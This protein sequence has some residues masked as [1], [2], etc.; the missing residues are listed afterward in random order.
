MGGRYQLLI[1]LIVFAVNLVVALVIGATN[2]TISGRVGN[3][4]PI[5][6]ILQAADYALIA[7]RVYVGDN[8]ARLVPAISS[9][10]G[11]LSLALVGFLARDS[12]LLAFPLALC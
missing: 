3:F 7:F 5:L 6:P 11:C 2:L 9:A 8:W 12:S 10:L 1:V 4:P